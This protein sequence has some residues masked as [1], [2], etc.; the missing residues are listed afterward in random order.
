MNGDA[1]ALA[2]LVR[3]WGTYY[4]ISSGADLYHAERRDN[5]ARTHEADPAQLRK[6][7]EADFRARPVILPPAWSRAEWQLRVKAA[8]LHPGVLATALAL[9]S[10]ADDQGVASLGNSK[11]AGLSQCSPATVSSRLFRLRLE[12]LIAREGIARGG[13]R[14]YRLVI[15]ATPDV[16]QSLPGNAGFS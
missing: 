9:A 10:G 11:L 15:P 4:V 7:I 16:G 2:E 14:S 5:G 12:G 6:E 1:A 3:D 8:G 13:M